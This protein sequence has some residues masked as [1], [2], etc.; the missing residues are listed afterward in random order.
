MAYISKNKKIVTNLDTLDFLRAALIRAREAGIESI[1]S[2]K[3]TFDTDDQDCYP[4]G[5]RLT[6]SRSSSEW[7]LLKIL[8]EEFEWLKIDKRSGRLSINPNQSIQYRLTEY[9]FQQAVVNSHNQSGID[10][11]ADINWR[12]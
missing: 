5:I 2:D 9:G 4:R 8:E 3:T 1:L 11:Y 12:E 10:C 7:T 6:F